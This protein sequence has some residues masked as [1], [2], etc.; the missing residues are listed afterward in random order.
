MS[1]TSNTGEITDDGL[2]RLRSRLGVVIENRTQPHVE[3]ASKDTI[4]HFA[5]GMGDPNPLYL[6]EDYAKAS[7]VGAMIA[8]PAMLYAFDRVVSGY[9]GGL[10]GVHAL[11]AGTEFRWHDHIR[12]GDTITAKASLKDVELKQSQFSKRAVKQTYLIEFY[13]QNGQMVADADSWCFRTERH[14]ARGEKKYAEIKPQEGYSI[15]EIEA[16]ADAY[17]RY[18]PQGAEPL[19]WEDV[20][21]G[22]D[23]PMLQ[24][25]PLT[26]TGMICWDQGWGGLYIRAH[27]MAFDMFEQ[28]PALGI[29]NL[30]GVP[31]VPERVHWEEALAKHIGAPGAYD[32]G[33][34]RIAWLSQAMTDFVGD[35]GF[36]KKLY[37]E[38]RRFNVVGDLTRISGKVTD[39]YEEGGEKLIECALVAHNQRGETTSFGTGVARLPSRG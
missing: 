7:P 37:A 39:K 32:Y 12:R 30:Q 18:K 3:E 38:V 35:H 19:Y 5:W 16:I 10:P 4:R 28:H 36:V 9:V 14:T 29:P 1:T 22:Q 25:G 6:D 31:D 27:K 8:P 33:P 13:N 24:K 26:V 15:E 23:M 17:R 21:V 34:E 20:S 11:F 2:S